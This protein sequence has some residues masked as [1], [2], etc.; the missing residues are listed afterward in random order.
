MGIHSI[1]RSRAGATHSARFLYISDKSSASTSALAQSLTLGV[2]IQ[3][4][5]GA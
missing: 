4:D 3:K 2:Y 5:I 1:I